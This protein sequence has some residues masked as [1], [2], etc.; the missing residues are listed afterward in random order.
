MRESEVTGNCHASFGERDRETR[1]PRGGK[2]RSVPTPLS[3]ILANIYLDDFDEALQ[4]SRFK[5][6]RFADDFVR[7][8]ARIV[9][10]ARAPAAR[11]RVANLSP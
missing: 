2:V 10:G 8:E 1:S 11:R 4:A 9:H 3:P 7:H 5:L 6:V